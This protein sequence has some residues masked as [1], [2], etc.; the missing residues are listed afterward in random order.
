MTPS[1]RV[2]LKRFAALNAPLFLVISGL[3][4]L[5]AKILGTLALPFLAAVWIEYTALYL[6][7]A[8][9]PAIVLAL[10]GGR[11]RAGAPAVAATTTT[12]FAFFLFVDA[13]IFR[14][15]GFHWNGFVWNLLTTRGGIESMDGGVRMWV[16]GALV[17]AVVA[18]LEFVLLRLARRDLATWRAFAPARPRRATLALAGLLLLLGVG[19]RLAFAAANFTGCREVTVGQDVFPFY[20][21]TRLR[22][23]GMALGFD[24]RED[25]GMRDVRGSLELHYPLAPL[26]VDPAARKLNVVWLVAESWRAD[27]MVPDL[28]PATIAFAERSLWFKHHYSGGNCTRMG[29]FSMFYGLYGCY[30]FPFIAARRGPVLVDRLLDDGW[31]F[32]VST[33]AKFTFPEFD[34]TVWSRFPMAELTEGDEERPGWENDREL[35]DKMLR[36]IDERDPARPFFAFHF[37]ESP[38]ARYHFPPECAIRRPYCKVVDYALL[39]ADD[40][41]EVKNRYLNSVNHLDTQFAKVLAHL[42]SRGLLDS[43]IVVLTGDHGE[44]FMEKGRYGHHSAFSEEQTRPPLILWIPGEAARTI[45][46]L[47]SHLDLPATLLARLGVTNDPADYS[48]G[49]DLLGP[50]RRDHVVIADWDQLCVRDAHGKGAFPLAESGLFDWEATSI[51]DAPFDDPRDWVHQASATLGL[52]ARAQRRFTR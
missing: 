47:S 34:E 11:A 17:L 38:H 27:T 51:D 50:A 48:L 37:F 26:R 36:R 7:V 1:V 46:T 8:L 40:M 5:Q 45:D 14:M 33:S 25:L 49:I 30:W 16:G 32:M 15:Y 23:F 19:E 29:V 44:E 20:L 52:V 35:T 31:Q 3:N 22:K 39:S 18:G 43:T 2:V 9:L 24:H 12:L 10:V 13:T 6:L 41:P 21:R 28:M 4:L 42:E